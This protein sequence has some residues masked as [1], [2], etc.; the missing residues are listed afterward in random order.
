MPTYMAFTLVNPV[1]D[2]DELRDAPPGT[3]LSGAA[4]ERRLERARQII[5]GAMPRLVIGNRVRH[6]R[7]AATLFIE[8]EQELEGLLTELGLHFVRCSE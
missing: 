2:E 4:C 1:Q 7:P 6:D 8:T 3:V 5:I